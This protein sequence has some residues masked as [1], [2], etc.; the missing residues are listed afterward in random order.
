MINTIEIEKATIFNQEG[1]LVTAS[2]SEPKRWITK[3]TKTLLPL[4]K[5]SVTVA[6][7]EALSLFPSNLHS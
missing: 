1:R 5:F 6:P 2:F 7:P 4:G 3:L